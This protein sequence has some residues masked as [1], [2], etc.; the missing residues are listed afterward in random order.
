MV[1]TANHVLVQGRTSIIAINTHGTKA[2]CRVLAIDPSVDLGLIQCDGFNLV[3]GV[4]K[5][6]PLFLPAGTRVVTSGYPGPVGHVIG[7]GILANHLPD[8]GLYVVQAPIGPGMSGGPVFTYDGA[9]I[10]LMHLVYPNM[11]FTGFITSPLTLQ[12]FLKG[13]VNAN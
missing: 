4:S 5:F 12:M 13:N 1:V 9:L 10:G 2:G 6:S 8:K 7:D 11:P 3:D